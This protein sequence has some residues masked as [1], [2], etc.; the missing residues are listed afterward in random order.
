MRPKTAKSTSLTP[1]PAVSSEKK[2]ESRMTVAT[3]AIGAAAITIWPNADPA[4]PA[5]LSSGST[6]A[7][8]VAERITATRNGAPTIPAAS[9]P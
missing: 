2:S 1:T 8:D 6:T 7:S 3:S 4:R 9:R 5:S